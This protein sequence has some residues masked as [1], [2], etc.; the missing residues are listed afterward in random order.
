MRRVVDV[1]SIIRCTKGLS[2]VYAGATLVNVGFTISDLM[3]RFDSFYLR[4]AT[5]SS[6][7][8]QL[9]INQ[10]VVGSNPAPYV[11]TG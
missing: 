6:T 1:D 8:E 5:A 2:C 7:V 4:H 11:K 3:L 9:T 10:C